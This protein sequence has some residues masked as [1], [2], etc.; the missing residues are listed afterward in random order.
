MW[1]R[2]GLSMTLAVDIYRR[3]LPPFDI[4]YRTQC[5]HLLQKAL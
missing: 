3:A 5:R 1:L 4:L 2:L